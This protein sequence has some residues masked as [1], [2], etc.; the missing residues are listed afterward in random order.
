L[1]INAA[2]PGEKGE[3]DIRL[4]RLGRREHR[5]I[6]DITSLADSI[7]DAGL[8]HRIAVSP[9]YGLITGR[10]RLAAC[11]H[12]GWD[13]I[14][15][16]TIGTVPEALAV[17]AEEDADPRQ[18]LPMTIAEAIYRD[19][20]VRDLLEWWPRAGHNRAVQGAREE[21]RD[22]LAR[23]AG[24]NGSQYTRAYAVILAAEGWCRKMNHLHPLEDEAEIEAA[25]EAA[26]TLQTA[27]SPGLVDA[28]YRQYRAMLAPPD[29]TPPAT[30]ADVDAA[31]ARLTGMT[32]AFGGIVLP[33]DAS[34]EMLQRWDDVM[35]KQVVRPLME[36]RRNR[37]RRST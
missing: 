15:Y 24:L 17:I 16:R 27:V 18:A 30:A 28:A 3:A 29:T 14:P 10:R 32:A 12:L 21:R 2:V 11:Q 31:L 22:L 26:K 9:G 20:Q 7:R 5:G 19:W 1:K 6:G 4:I 36:F 23:A 8:R 13:R 35:T 33:P 25:R 34:P 37:I